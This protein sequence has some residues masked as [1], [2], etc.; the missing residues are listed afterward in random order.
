VDLQIRETSGKLLICLGF[1]CFSLTCGLFDFDFDIMCRRM[2]PYIR[3]LLRCMI[4][5]IYWNNG[6][7]IACWLHQ[8]L[9]TSFTY[10]ISHNKT[11]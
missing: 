1:E 11:M 10:L 8:T 4:G 6:M 9:G 5:G 3:Y 7:V 2:T